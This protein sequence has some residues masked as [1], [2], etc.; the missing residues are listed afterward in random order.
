MIIGKVVGKVISTRKNEALVGCK[1]LVVEILSSMT[2]DNTKMVAVDNVG[3]GIGDIVLVA[4]GSAARLA[5]ND[6]N[7]PVD[8]AVVGIVDD[9]TGL[10]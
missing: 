9:G 10:E 6:G 7:T 5:C 1:F 8:A 3:A 4:Q 2:N